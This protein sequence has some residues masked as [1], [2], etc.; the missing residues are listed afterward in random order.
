MLNAEDIKWVEALRKMTDITTLAMKVKNIGVQLIWTLL[1]NEGKTIERILKK[2]SGLTF[3]D[4]SITTC[5]I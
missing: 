3:F 2:K 1:I 5:L 4:K